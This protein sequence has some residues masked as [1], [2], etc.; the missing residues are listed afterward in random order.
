MSSEQ[1]D[2]PLVKADAV[3]RRLYQ[4]VIVGTGV[5]HNSLVVLPTG[6]GKTIIAALIAA[7]RLH[8]YSN[9]KCVFL[10]PTRP[11][12]LQH[13]RTFRKMLD[14]PESE[15]VAFTGS[16]KPLKRIQL[17][18][19]SRIIFMTPQ[20]LENDLI[21]GRYPIEDVSLVVFDEAHRAVGSY[22]YTFIAEQYLKRAKNPRIL[23]LTA[24]PGSSKT[25][26]KEVCE[27]LFIENVEVRTEKD[28]DVAPYLVPI[29][30]DWKL[31]D[32]PPELSTIKKELEELLRERLKLLKSYGFV[33]SYD[34]KKVSRKD[35]IGLRA[36]IQK[37]LGSTCLTKDQVKELTK[38][39]L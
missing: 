6:L 29:K 25:K 26:I 2:H 32:L 38:I 11:L 7:H 8:K 12:V 28:S 30:L 17:W 4:E 15:L 20:I 31:I 3:E 10:A 21:V 23:G 24:S 36:K 33:K 5:A 13:R 19:E 39:V 1:T 16:I 9:S 35:L 22:P 34:V 18:K 27:N 37:E 14:V